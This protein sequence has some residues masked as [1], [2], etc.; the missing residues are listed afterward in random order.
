MLCFAASAEPV[1]DADPGRNGRP[2]GVLAGARRGAPRGETRAKGGRTG[3]RG[4]LKT[5]APHQEENST[6]DLPS[7]TDLIF[8]KTK[9]KA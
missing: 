7:P 4:T 8:Y 6:K 5:K 3:I 2:G 1:R 9:H